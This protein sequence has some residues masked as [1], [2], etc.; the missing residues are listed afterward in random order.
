M[1]PPN[2]VS[3]A[4]MELG[5]MESIPI[6]VPYKPNATGPI[7]TPLLMQKKTEFVGEKIESGQ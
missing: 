4:V 1:I 6:G 3:P 5:D 2:N 7:Q